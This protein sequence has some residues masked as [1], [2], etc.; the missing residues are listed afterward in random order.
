VD[1]DFIFRRFGDHI[2][3]G[4]CYVGQ[5]LNLRVLRGF[6]QLD[7]LAFISA[8]DVF[9]QVDNPLG[10]QRALSPEHARDCRE[11]ALEATGLPAEE[12]PR[13]FPD[14]LLNVRDTNVVE[15]YNIEDPEELYEFDSF[16]D[17]TEVPAN[18][19]GVRIS[20]QALENP[21][22]FHNPQVS[23]V[24]GN[25]RLWGMDEILQQEAETPDEGQSID[26]VPTVAFSMLVGLTAKQ[27][28]SLFRDING[29]HKGMDVTHLASIEARITDPAELRSDP[30]R[31]PLWVADQLS[32]P[33]RAFENMVFLGGE[34][35]GLKR[36]GEQ[37]PVK[38]NSLRTTLAQQLRSAPRATA[39]FGDEPE[40]LL[41]MLDNFWKAVRDTFPEAWSDRRDYILLQAIGLG[42]FAKFGGAILDSAF[43]N[44]SMEY[45]DFVR[46]L[47]PVKDKV[48]L[49]RDEYR[50]IAGAGGAQVIADK[51]LKASE[52]DA[53]RAARIRA[54][55]QG[56]DSIDEKLGIAP[57]ED[58]HEPVEAASQNRE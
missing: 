24:D 34:R 49:R 7:S 51:L 19:V 39:H 4:A 21:K 41:G 32:Q 56:Q 53:V 38:L 23:R 30:K 13:F 57:A 55:L 6:G 12:S 2:D 1:P 8:P 44:G 43:E 9:D 47:E 16:A 20:L 28:A 25:H 40:T 29:E 54:Q 31:L 37:R 36:L 42:A 45:A 27:E 15:L 58:Q 3:F 35:T 17:D 18:F 11:Y 22:A 50:G 14:I 26:D 48:S 5:N 33:G 46:F 10:T 52:P